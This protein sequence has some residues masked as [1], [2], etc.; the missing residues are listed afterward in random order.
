[1]TRRP[2]SPFPPRLQRAAPFLYRGSFPR[3]CVDMHV[4]FGRSSDGEQVTE[5]DLDAYFRNFPVSH[6]VVFPIDVPDSGP[7]YSRVNSRVMQAARRNPRILPFC[8]LDPKGGQAAYR[9][10]KRCAGAGIRGVKLHPATDRF[11][12]KTAAPLIE[13]IARRRLPVLLHTAHEP[14]TRPSKWLEIFLRHRE[15]YF[16]LG[17]SGKDCY[18]EA[19]EVARRCPNVFLDPSTLSYRRTNLLVKRAGARKVV[20]ATDVP[21]SHPAVEFMKYELILSDRSSARRLIFHEN[22]E[23]ILGGFS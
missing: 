18:P 10:L 19:I 14:N 9:E 12:T 6:L 17:H 2:A 23:R 15:N 8:R 7:S 5:V 13:E 3:T 21:Y 22:P 16:I 1:M 4:H 20:F 11:D